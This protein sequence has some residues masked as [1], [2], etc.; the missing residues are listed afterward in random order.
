MTFNP[1][2]KAPVA[3]YHLLTNPDV[4]GTPMEFYK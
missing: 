1:L 2:D 3:K 4:G